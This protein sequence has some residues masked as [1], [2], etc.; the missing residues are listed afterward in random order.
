MIACTTVNENNKLEIFPKASYIILFDLEKKEV[1]KRVKNTEH[2][3]PAVTKKCLELR[4]EVLIAPHGSLCFPSYSLAKKANVK[5][6]VDDPGKVFNEISPREITMREVMYSS[7]L[8][9]YQ[10]LTFR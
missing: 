9:I 2:S 5:I 4:P 7:L 1:I 3:R 10:R 8:A 6:L